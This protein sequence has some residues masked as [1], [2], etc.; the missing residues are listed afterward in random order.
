MAELSSE[1]T[2]M[3]V[4]QFAK[5]LFRA[6]DLDEIGLFGIAKALRN[7]VPEAL[8]NDGF[9][10]KQVEAVVRASRILVKETE[11]DLRDRRL[12]QFIGGNI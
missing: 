12:A 11:S 3:L 8:I 2:G 6:K 1:E 7:R 9:P 5:D 4:D 10:L